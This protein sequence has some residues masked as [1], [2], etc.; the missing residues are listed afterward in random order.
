[1][2]TVAGVSCMYFNPKKYNHRSFIHYFKIRREERSVSTTRK[3][4]LHNFWV[5]LSLFL[6]CSQ[7]SCYISSQKPLMTKLDHCNGCSI[8]GL[9]RW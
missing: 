5:L 7:F 6:E 4:V 1:M 9:K 3:V 2:N 8:H